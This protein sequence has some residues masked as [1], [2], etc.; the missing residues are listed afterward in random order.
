MHN[1]SSFSRTDAH[2]SEVFYRFFGVFLDS[3]RDRDHAEDIFTLCENGDRLA[4][5]GELIRKLLDFVVDRDMIPDKTQTAAEGVFA[6]DHARESFAE[7]RMKVRD[8]IGGDIL[9]FS[10]AQDRLGERMI[11]VLLQSYGESK[12]FLLGIS[13]QRD[14]VCDLGSAFGDGAGL[15]QRED[16]RSAGLFQRF[17]SRLLGG[18]AS[19]VLGS[20]DRVPT[21]REP[22]IW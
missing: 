1:L 2:R 7:Y 22:G 9:L 8:F 11:A 10:T 13:R 12:Q 20:R 5:I 19:R 6:V 21:D 16:L 18:Y 3:V 4:L 17:G 15:V 14:N